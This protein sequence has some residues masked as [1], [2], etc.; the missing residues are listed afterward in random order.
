MSSP[1]SLRIDSEI[2]QAEVGQRSIQTPTHLYLTRGAWFL[3]YF[4]ND[5]GEG[6]DAVLWVCLKEPCFHESRQLISVI[7]LV[8]RRSQQHEILDS[9][10]FAAQSPCQVVSP[11]LLTSQIKFKPD[12]LNDL[13]IYWQIPWCAIPLT[14]CDGLRALCYLSDS[15]YNIYRLLFVRN[16]S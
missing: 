2:A 3:P 9:V 1:G 4:L 11:E 10:I 14:T 12:A 6:L 15:S 16:F 13:A 7:R 5:H 8:N